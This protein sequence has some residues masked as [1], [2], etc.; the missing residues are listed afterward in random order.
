VTRAV[1]PLGRSAITVACVA[2]GA[3][4][5][6]ARYRA[7][8]SVR[9]Y[10]VLITRQDSLSRAVARGLERRGY[11]V[12]TAVA[13]GSRATAYLLSFT[14]RE[15]EPGAPTW[16]YIRLAD[17]RTGAIVAAVSAPLD[18]LGA[19]VLTRAQAIVDSLTRRV[20]LDAAP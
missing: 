19:T 1:L 12:R 9:G 15:I 5:P 7:P 3:C 13:G 18:S 6:T 20:P 14:Q 11:T 2:L 16:L 4:A 10:D 17:T 8:S